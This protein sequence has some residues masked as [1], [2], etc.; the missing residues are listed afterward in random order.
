MNKTITILLVDD[1]DVTNYYHKII[2]DEMNIC[3]KLQICRDGQ[4]ALNYLLCKGKYVNNNQFPSPDLI[5]LDI[6]MPGMNG[7]EFLEKYKDLPQEQK[8]KYLYVMLT[9]PL[10]KGD[11]KKITDNKDVKD[12]KSKPLTKEYLKKVINLL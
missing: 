12:L 8:A 4:D 6:N 9:I 5:F 11:K 7:F 2:I 1:N 10:N 3:N